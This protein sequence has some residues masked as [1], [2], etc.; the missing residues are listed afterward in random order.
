MITIGINFMNL[1]YY[2]KVVKHKQL[3]VKQKLVCTE[4]LQMKIIQL[5]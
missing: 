4:L 5:K 1:V 2:F 3:M